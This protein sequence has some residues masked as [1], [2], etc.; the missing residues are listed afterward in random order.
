MTVVNNAIVLNKIHLV[1]TNINLVCRLENVFCTHLTS[2]MDIFGRSCAVGIGEESHGIGDGVLSGSMDVAGLNDGTT[3]IV[4]C[5]D[6]GDEL[7]NLDRKDWDLADDNSIDCIL[8]SCFC[9]NNNFPNLLVN[10][11]NNT[12][13]N[14]ASRTVTTIVR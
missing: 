7:L 13:T 6:I 4:S 1:I 9:N 8:C 14:N 11:S 2:C 3:S 12:M 5:L 10:I